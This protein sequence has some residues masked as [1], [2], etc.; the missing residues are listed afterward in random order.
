MLHYDKITFKN[1]HEIE[2]YFNILLKNCHD[3]YEIKEIYTI[4]YRLIE[5]QKEN[6]IVCYYGNKNIMNEYNSLSSFRTSQIDPDYQQRMRDQEYYIMKRMY[7]ASTDPYE[8][9]KKDREK[10]ELKI[11][12]LLLL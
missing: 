5:S 3:P 10:E 9:L 7:N 1:K 2:Y 12:K 11:K 8:V 6:K 4:R